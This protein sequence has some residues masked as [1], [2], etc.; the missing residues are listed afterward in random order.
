MPRA[1]LLLN[2][3]KYGIRNNIPMFRKV[4]EAIIKKYAEEKNLKY[5]DYHSEMKDEKN[6]L[7]K[8]YTEDGVHP[9]EKGYQKMEKILLPYLY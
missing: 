2:L 4:A 5:V 6:G 1:D 3:V 7:D 9:N 8:I